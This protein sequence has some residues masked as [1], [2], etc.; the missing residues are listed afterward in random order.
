MQDFSEGRV[1]VR[2]EIFPGRGNH[3]ARENFLR[4]GRGNVRVEILPTE[5]GT[6]SERGK[7]FPK[8]AGAIPE[9]EEICTT[10]QV[11]E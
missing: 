4:Q 5:A 11:S 7:N 2:E 9:R 10:G 8:G 6:I 1:H 3:G